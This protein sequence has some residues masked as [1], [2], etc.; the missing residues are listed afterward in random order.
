M[1]ALEVRRTGFADK[2]RNPQGQ[3]VNV[4]FANVVS[5]PV[6]PPQPSQPQPLASPQPPLRI[7]ASEPVEFVGGNSNKRVRERSP[8]SVEGEGEG[9]K[10]LKPLLN[11]ELLEQARKFLG[12]NENQEAIAGKDLTQHTDRLAYATAVA[13]Q[14]NGLA[15]IEDVR[16]HGGAIWVSS[17]PRDADYGE[18]RCVGLMTSCARKTEEEHLANVKESPAPS[19]LAQGSGQPAQDLAARKSQQI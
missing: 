16:I 5:A 1:N 2:F 18:N 17:A 4:E 15:K 7:D 19:G 13:A 11:P 3:P 8:E 10:A 6:L 9:V 12:S 14:N